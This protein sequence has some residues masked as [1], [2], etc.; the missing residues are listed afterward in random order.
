[1]PLQFEYVTPSTGAKATY[2]V[3]QQ[4]GL[5]Y[6]STLTSVTIASYL[7]K[8]ARDAGKYSMYAQ[9]IQIGALPDSGIDARDFAESSLAAAAPTDG[10]ASVNPG[11]YVFAGAEISK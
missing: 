11:R 5:D 3:V 7:S 8:E 10:S 6:V 2:H 1:M 4:V 9:Q